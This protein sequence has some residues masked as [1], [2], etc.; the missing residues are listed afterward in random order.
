MRG[1]TSDKHVL[2]ISTLIGNECSIRATSFTETSA[3]DCALVQLRALIGSNP[4]SALRASGAP[5]NKALLQ[6]CVVFSGSLEQVNTKRHS[7]FGPECDAAQRLRHV[8]TVPFK[9]GA[10]D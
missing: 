4:R 6:S 7:P 5:T 8:A 2:A 10:T 1:K 3:A 9:A